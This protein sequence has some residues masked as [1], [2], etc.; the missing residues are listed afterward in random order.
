[1][2]IDKPVIN[3]SAKTT[4]VDADSVSLTDSEE[5]SFLKLL[6]W[7]NLKVALKSY[8]DVIYSA[9]THTHPDLGL[10]MI[11]TEAT[12]LASTP[13]EKSIAWATDT[14]RF[15]MADGSNWYVSSAYLDLQLEA[16]DMGPESESNRA[17]YGREYITDKDIVNCAIG[18][19]SATPKEGS[20]RQ[21]PVNHWLQ[22]YQDGAWQTIVANLEM[23]ESAGVLQHKPVGY[24][25]W[26]NVY[27]G[28]SV[29]V[30]LNGVPLILGYKVS[31]GPSPFNPNISG[32]SF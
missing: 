4:P 8:F 14:E 30:G 28:N 6:T 9:I 31:M 18:Y 11:D 32:G 27:S 15:L 17:G 26:I 25:A 22:I 16:P 24:D 7:A 10:S 13:T 2:R 12:I 29:L 1:M 23:R 3:T 19:G 5:S 20:F 21:D